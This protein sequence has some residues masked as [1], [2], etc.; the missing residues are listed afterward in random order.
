MKETARA[1]EHLLK[2]LIVS[3]SSN[4]SPIRRKNFLGRGR[5]IANDAS[6]FTPSARVEPELIIPDSDARRKPG[7]AQMPFANWFADEWKF[8]D[9]SP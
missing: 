2:E 4:A 5:T 3:K 6:R 7:N 1:A 8:A 9:R